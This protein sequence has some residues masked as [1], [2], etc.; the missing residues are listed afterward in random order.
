MDLDNPSIMNYNIASCTVVF[1]FAIVYAAFHMEI[2]DVRQ[3][4]WPICGCNFS[5]DIPSLKEYISKHGVPL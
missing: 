5:L 1:L 4:M 3:T 2:I